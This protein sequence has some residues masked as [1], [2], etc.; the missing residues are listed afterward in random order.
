[1]KEDLAIAKNSILALQEENERFRLAYSEAHY[2]QEDTRVCL[3]VISLYR[4]DLVFNLFLIQST[5]SDK[6][7]EKESF[8]NTQA[9]TDSA[10]TDF[11]KLFHEELQKRKV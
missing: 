6:S 1:M 5:K 11:K 9:L 4:S 3:T 7:L 10:P 8:Q 2:V